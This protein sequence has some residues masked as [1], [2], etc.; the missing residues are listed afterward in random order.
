MKKC[1][2]RR[3]RQALHLRAM[4][5][6]LTRSISQW[7]T[8]EVSSLRKRWRDATRKELIAEFPR[9][10]WTSIQGKGRTFGIRRRPWKQKLTGQRMLDEI[11]QRSADLRISHGDLD[12]ICVG[13][14][15]FRNSSRRS[16]R[17]RRNVLLRAIAA[18]GGSVEIVWS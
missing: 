14:R 12:R 16:Q 13:R 11:R 2:R 8:G 15:Y 9:H 1:L 5:L 3:S 4:K 6:K 18:L 7:T 17:P 10:T